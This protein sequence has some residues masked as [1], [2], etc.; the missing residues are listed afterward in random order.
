MAS[1]R[2]SG[3]G[4]RI[5]FALL[6]ALVLPVLALGCSSP[7]QI[8]EISPGRGVRDVPTN[9][10]IRIRFDRSLDRA[11]VEKRFS[12]HP[13]ADGQV[14]WEAPN[15]LV[16]RH[17]TLQPSTRYEVLLSSGYRDAAGNVNGFNHSWTFQTEAPPELRSTSPSAGDAQVDPATYL[18]LAFSREMDAESF[19][20]SV[21]FSPS[22]SFS[23][24]G[25]PTD[26]RRVLIAPKSLLT[27]GTEYLV[28]IS[29][30]ATDADGNHLGPIK[31][32]F[33]T[34]PVRPLTRWITF[35]ASE[36]GAAAGS[37][38]WMVDDAGFPRILEET[39]TDRFSLSPDGTNLLV[40]HPDRTWTD[41]QLGSDPVELGFSADWAAYL[42]PSAGF[43]FLDGSHLGRV[44]P[45]GVTVRIADDVGLAAVSPDL[46]RI[47]FV[48][49]LVGGGSDIRA[50]DVPLRAQYRV[51]RE[52]DPVD[53]VAWAPDGTKL[54]YLAVS[55]TAPRQVSL[56]VRNL[57]AGAS[58]SNIVS[59]QLEDF[60][61]LADSTYITFSA[62]V[63]VSGTVRSRIFR[64]NTALPQSGLNAASAIGPAADT[65]AFLPRPSPDGHQIAFLQGAAESAQ[66][67]LMN[68]DGTGASRL[69]GFDSESFPFSCHDLHW[70]G[71]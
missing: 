54:A 55:G 25:D 23:V 44:L 8:L 1:A 34:G 47:A 59:G 29:D 3:W 27:A 62:K 16:F 15:T 35:I 24:E 53:E 64:V 10:P 31:L 51:Q 18:S 37:G 28:S 48:Q 26:T 36:T 40:R 60:A 32:R 39:A 61:W 66:I 68:A 2:P 69:T 21:T 56:R 42:G 41:Y 70:A 45:S 22:T 13:A 19:R 43:A 14:A 58:S 46:A 65:D 5:G 57:T 49:S 11:S 7:P 71:P 9:A 12:L 17:E 50:Y 4:S 38:I 6:L 52:N 33:T 20:G 63:S 30:N 67:W